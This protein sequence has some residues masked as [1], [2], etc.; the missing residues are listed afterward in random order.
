MAGFQVSTEDGKPKQRGALSFTD[1]CGV[2]NQLHQ[3]AGARLV[4]GFDEH[5][6]DRMDAESFLVLLLAL[7]EVV[8]RAEFF[9]HVG[10]RHGASV[11]FVA[12]VGDAVIG[13][14]QTEQRIR[15]Y[16]ESLHSVSCSVQTYSLLPS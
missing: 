8:V 11:C 7:N 6:T 3:L 16:R 4:C 2:L 1:D 13:K 12:E 15:F 14:A 5:G 9:Q 10:H